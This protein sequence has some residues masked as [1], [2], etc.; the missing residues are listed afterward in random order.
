MLAKSTP[1]EVP[2]T[3]VYLTQ[4]PATAPSALLHNLKHNRV[5]HSQ[6]FIVT[7]STAPTP[8]VSDANRIALERLSDKFLRVTMTF[9]YMETPN[10]PKALS[11]ARK[12]GEKF[13]IMTTSFF[14]NRRTF[15]SARH[16]GLPFWQERVFISLSRSAADATAFYCLPSNRVVEMGQQMAI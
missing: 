13:D 15:R 1:I 6:N 9:G 4:D 8:P 14:L 10:V 7:V 11:L 12:R 2:G 3:A 16:Q 5:L